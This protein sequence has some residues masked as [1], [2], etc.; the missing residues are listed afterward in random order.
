MKKKNREAKTKQRSRSLIH[1]PVV[2][3][4]VLAFCILL[5]Q[6]APESPLRWM[7]I[8]GW[9]MEF[10]VAFRVPLRFSERNSW[11]RL[12]VYRM[13][14]SHIEFPDRC[15][16]RRHRKVF[17]KIHR[18]QVGIWSGRD[19]RSCVFLSIRQSDFQSSQI[20]LQGQKERTAPLSPKL[21]GI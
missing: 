15:Q 16:S 4:A 12:I 14:T 9:W 3:P 6:F 8:C 21:V 10:E 19:L 13:L 11:N 2:Q 7:H 17:Q 20:Y 1:S 18:Q 5:P